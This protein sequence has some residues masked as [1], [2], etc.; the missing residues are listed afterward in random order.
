MASTW[1]YVVSVEGG[2]KR[3]VKCKF[4]ECSFME[5]AYRVRH[6]LVGTG[7]DVQPCLM[8]PL[9]VKNVMQ[10]LIW[11]ELIDRKLAEM[12]RELV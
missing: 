4:S 7:R 8:V 6:H 12:K 2:T 5:G 11:L 1:Q 10:I 9:D 3:K